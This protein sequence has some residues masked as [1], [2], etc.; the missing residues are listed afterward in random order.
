MRFYR[1]CHIDTKQG[2]WY[3]QDGEFTG[4]IHKGL[5]F[6]KNNK[7]AM[8]F[9]IEICGYLSAVESLS[10]LF[11]WFSEADILKLQEHNFFIHVYD[12]EDYKIYHKFNHTVINK[13]NSKLLNV[14]KL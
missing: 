11:N 9:D 2:L 6:C 1:V 4:L 12:S 3:D 7:L 14:I 5:N 10:D 8:D 13:E